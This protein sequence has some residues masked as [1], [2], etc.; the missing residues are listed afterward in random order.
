MSH[1]C[2]DLNSDDA[3]F[4][5]VDVIAFWLGNLGMINSGP[6]KLLSTLQGILRKKLK[7]H[8]NNNNGEC[9]SNACSQSTALVSIP[10]L[11]TP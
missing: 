4:S 2:Y 8:F 3:G 5:L 10:T 1:F 6:F 9:N 7:C 11:V